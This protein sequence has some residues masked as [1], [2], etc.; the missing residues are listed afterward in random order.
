[1]SNNKSEVFFD[2]TVF[3]GYDP[4]QVDEFVNEARKMLTGFKKENQ[5]L[6]QKLQVLAEALEE[7]RNVTPAPEGES[8]PSAAPDAPEAPEA[9]AEQSAA[10]LAE[11]PA[12]DNAV[13]LEELNQQLSELLEQIQQEQNRLSELRREHAA[14]I[15]SLTE[16]YELQ[17]RELGEASHVSLQAEPVQSDAVEAAPTTQPV[18][19]NDS[20]QETSATD[21]AATQPSEEDAASLTNT[22]PESDE[23]MLSAEIQETATEEE[24]A[25]SPKP[26]QG[27]DV[28]APV[29]ATEPVQVTE[30]AA[31]KQETAPVS[32][33]PVQP[34]ATA[35][36]QRVEPVREANP[37][38][39]VDAGE[40]VYLNA[41]G[42]DTSNLSYEEALALV[43]KK[44]GILSQAPDRSADELSDSQATKI[45][46][47]IPP[48]SAAQTAAPAPSEK[49]K[50]PG[51]FHSLKSSIRAFLD[52]DEEEDVIQP[53]ANK[54]GQE[55]LQFGKAYNVKN[56]R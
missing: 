30:D 31:P 51:F 49:A 4:E 50:K 19:A 5:V 47:R 24:S 44:N 7:A 26:A 56:D 3:G 16:Q 52:E 8:Q 36:A 33:P 28:V 38:L 45:I 20:V 9:V 46:P 14:F 34:E 17:L 53:V 41:Q 35:P 6:K 23:P 32:A 25:P 27:V 43:L 39:V 12:A 21:E 54:N 1:M 10:A 2:K 48:V 22:E 37:Q 42:V 15:A 18:E 40:S 29:Q 55:E 11:A 13:Q